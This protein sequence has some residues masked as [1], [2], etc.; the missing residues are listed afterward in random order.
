[1]NVDNRRTLT[2]AVNVPGTQLYD[3]QK[4]PKS[5]PTRTK[6]TDK[7]NTSGHLFRTLGLQF[8]TSAGCRYK[9]LGR[10]IQKLRDGNAISE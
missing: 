9:P 8:S 3:N 10:E 4:K 7:S 5:I 1:M 2:L 6:K